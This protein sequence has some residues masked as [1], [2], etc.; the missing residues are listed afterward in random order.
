MLKDPA[1]HDRN[2]KQYQSFR[3]RFLLPY[4]VLQLL[5][6]LVK[7][8]G[9]FPKATKDV[10]GRN[11]IPLELNMGLWLFPSKMLVGS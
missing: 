8:R 6:G 2:S 3:R 11:C 5:V 9:W 1:L 7:E 10:A 4:S